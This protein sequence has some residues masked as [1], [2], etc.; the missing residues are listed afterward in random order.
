MVHTL[1]AMNMRNH[2]IM[3]LGLKKMYRFDL[4]SFLLGFAIAMGLFTL[5][6]MLRL[7]SLALKAF[8][9]Y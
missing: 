1:S 2:V 4:G 8:V 6:A 3:N 5:Y 9:G 7:N